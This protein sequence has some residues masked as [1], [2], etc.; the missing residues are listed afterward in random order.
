MA[1]EGGGVL[2]VVGIVGGLAPYADAWVGMAVAGDHL[3]VGLVEENGGN[4]WK[5]K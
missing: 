5:G 4:L 1:F 3:S 2:K